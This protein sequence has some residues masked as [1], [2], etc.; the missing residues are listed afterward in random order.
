MG[1]DLGRALAD[2]A[3]LP[4]YTQSA[5]GPDRQLIDDMSNLITLRRDIHFLFDSRRFTF[6]PKQNAKT[7]CLVLHVLSL[8]TDFIN[9]ELVPTY[10]NRSPAPLTGI[11]IQHLFA[12]FAWSLFSEPIMPFFKGMVEY[13]VLLFDPETAE[14]KE[15]KLRAT[16]IRSNLTIFDAPSRSRSVSPRKR[17][18]DSS[19]QDKY[20]EALEEDDAEEEEEDW[21]PRGRRRKRRCDHYIG[22]DTGLGEFRSSSAARSV[23]V[24]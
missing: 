24:Q 1:L 16:D 5:S 2:N 20:S 15:A 14:T 22:D 18:R 10:H 19:A 11:S 21:Q 23:A 3:A 6:V 13:R 7:C 12:R 17:Q 4:R 8:D 9:S